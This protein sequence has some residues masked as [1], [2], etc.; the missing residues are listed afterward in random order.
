[1]PGIPHPT[2]A[3]PPGALRKP[4]IRGTTPNAFALRPARLV[5]WGAIGDSPSGCV[6]ICTHHSRSRG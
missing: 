4:G 5:P 1:M 2:N 3:P 6:I